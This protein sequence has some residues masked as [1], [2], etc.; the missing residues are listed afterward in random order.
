VSVNCGRQ[1]RTIESGG[2]IRLLA[3]GSP[4]DF[5]WQFGQHPGYN[6]GGYCLFG[7]FYESELLQPLLQIIR[8][9]E[10]QDTVLYLGGYDVSVT[11]IV[12]HVIS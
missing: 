10:F 7:D 5:S 6:S 4:G 11:G 12:K 1:F 9:R 2:G 3:I 8:S